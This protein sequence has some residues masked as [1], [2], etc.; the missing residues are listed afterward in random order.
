MDINGT[1]GF[2]CWRRLAVEN[3]RLCISHYMSY[4]AMSRASGSDEV[5]K[6]MVQTQQNRRSVD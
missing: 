5:K 6:Q 4:K 3:K 2:S 1:K